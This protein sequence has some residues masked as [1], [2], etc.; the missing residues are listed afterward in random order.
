M[1][2]ELASGP[3]FPAWEEYLEELNPL[4]GALGAGIGH[5]QDPELCP[6]QVGSIFLH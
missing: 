4:L 2:E 1:V 5:P 3:W 6:E